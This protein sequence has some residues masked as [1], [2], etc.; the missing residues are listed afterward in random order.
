MDIKF[1]DRSSKP[2][3]TVVDCDYWLGRDMNLTHVLL[4]P[5]PY[6]LGRMAMTVL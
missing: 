4:Y 1:F 6:C 2:Q 3:V 5:Y